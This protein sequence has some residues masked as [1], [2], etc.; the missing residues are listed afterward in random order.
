LDFT[1]PSNYN[2]GTVDTTVGNS[3]LPLPRASKTIKIHAQN[4]GAQNGVLWLDYVFEATDGMEDRYGYFV[5]DPDVQ[6]G[7]NV[8]GQS[9]S[10]TVYEDPKSAVSAAQGWSKYAVKLALA[11]LSVVALAETF[12]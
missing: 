11:V 8:Q 10:V 3:G 4:G 7:L 1:F 5:Y 12:A 6:I 9:G 2:V